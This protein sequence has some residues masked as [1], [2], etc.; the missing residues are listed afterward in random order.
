MHR[1]SKSF[2]H[3]DSSAMMNHGQMN[4]KLAHKVWRPASHSRGC[5]ALTSTSCMESMPSRAKVSEFDTLLA[6]RPITERM[7][8]RR[9][10]R[11]ISNISSDGCPVLKQTIFKDVLD[12]RAY[13]VMLLML[14]LNPATCTLSELKEHGVHHGE[15]TAA[16]DRNLLLVCTGCCPPFCCWSLAF[17][18]G[19][20]A[21]ARMSSSLHTSLWIRTASVYLTSGGSCQS[22]E[23]WKP[24]AG[25]TPSAPAMGRMCA[26]TYSI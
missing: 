10:C 4:M 7:L 6:D 8:P 11:H 19:C 23:A 25:L 26:I 3:L 2:Q 13:T 18:P 12:S 21:A 15:A 16:A 24:R 20:P 5:L 17:C 22:A 14:H 1:A 9:S